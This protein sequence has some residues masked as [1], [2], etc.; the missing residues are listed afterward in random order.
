MIYTHIY[1]H[2]YLVSLFLADYKKGSCGKVSKLLILKLIIMNTV[3][4]N[5]NFELIVF[6][7]FM[8]YH[9]IL[10]L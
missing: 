5:L 2:L 1:H 8:N 3:L 10:N 4:K 7:I 6:E 9:R